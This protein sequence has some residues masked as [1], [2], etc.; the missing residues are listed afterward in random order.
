VVA[1]EFT[2]HLQG[3]RTLVVVSEVPLTRVVGQGAAKSNSIARTLVVS[4]A[5]FIPSTRRFNSVTVEGVAD[6]DVRT[7]G[8]YPR[9]ALLL[10]YSI[11]YGLNPVT[12]EETS[13]NV[14]V[15]VKG[16]SGCDA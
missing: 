12:T 8:W 6:I 2:A 1:S 3:I 14:L 10:K 13:K 9:R 5:T 4:N 11:F 15:K 16:T 7:G